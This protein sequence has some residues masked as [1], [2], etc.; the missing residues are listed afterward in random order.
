MDFK[1]K[2]NTLIGGFSTA[3]TKQVCPSSRT[4]ESK[5]PVYSGSPSCVL[6]YAHEFIIIMCPPYTAIH[7]HIG[8]H[9]YVH[10]HAHRYTYIGTYICI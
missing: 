9:T 3:A 2:Q 4:Y 8:I 6:T 5:C 1:C 10:T 7:M